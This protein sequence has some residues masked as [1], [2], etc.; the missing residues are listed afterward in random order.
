MVEELRFM[1]TVNTISSPYC[2]FKFSGSLNDRSNTWLEETG[3]SVNV[4]LN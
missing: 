2:N 3:Q 1:G 4:V